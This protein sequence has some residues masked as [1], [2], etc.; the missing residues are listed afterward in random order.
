MSPFEISVDGSS[1]GGYKG[2][3]SN[4]QDDADLAA[5]MQGIILRIAYLKIC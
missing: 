1:G 4:I 5:Y 2:I 3:N